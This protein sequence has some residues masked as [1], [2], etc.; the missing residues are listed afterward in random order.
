MVKR[1]LSF[2]LLTLALIGKVNAQYLSTVPPLAGGNGSGGVT[3][4]LSANASVIIDTIWCQFGGTGT[5]DIWYNTTAISG[6]PSISAPAWTNVVTGYA[7][8]SGFIGIPIPATANLMMSAGQT[9]GFYVGQGTSGTASVTYTTW[10]A[11]NVDTFFNNDITIRTGQQIGYGGPM[12]SPPNHPRQF[13]GAISYHLGIGTD[14]SASALVS[15]AA[16][17]T[18]GSTVAVSMELRCNASNPITTASVGYQLNNLPPVTGTWN[19]NIATGQTAVHTFPGN[20]TLPTSGTHILKV[21][22]TSPNGVNPDLNPMNDTLRTTIC[23]ALP[24]GTYTVGARTGTNFQTLQDA[25]NAIACG[26]IA[27]NV[28]FVLDTGTYTGSHV[29]NGPIAGTSQFN[30]TFVSANQNAASCRVENNGSGPV[31]RI[32]NV[33]NV[34]IRNISFQKQNTPTSNTEVPIHVKNGNMINILGCIAKG[35]STNN[36]NFNLSSIL[37]ENSSYVTIDSTTVGDSYYGIRF[38]GTA[39]PNRDMNNTVSH[40]NIVNA[41]YYGIYN[42]NQNTLV[43]DNNRITD[44]GLG[45]NNFAYGIYCSGDTST[46]ITNNFL[47]GIVPRYG[48]YLTNM[49]GESTNPNKVNNNVI[50]GVHYYVSGAPTGI[51]VSS[52]TTNGRDAIDIIHN[53][54]NI[55]TA[56]TSTSNNSGPGGLYITGT[57]YAALQIVNNTFNLKATQG[58]T[59]DPTVR[60]IVIASQAAVD[61]A[62]MNY[63][64]YF[65]GASNEVSRIAGT[66]YTTLA[67]H[68]AGT[69]RDANSLSL[70]PNYVSSSLPRP[71]SSAMDNMGTVTYVTADITG[72]TR[73]VLT[74]DIGAYEFTPSPVEAQMNSITGL[75]GGCGL[76]TDT[77][78][79][80]I[81]NLG[82]ATLTN[83]P[84]FYSVNGA[85]PVA[86]TVPGPVSAGQTAT[87]AF[88][89]LVNLAT[90]GTY[91]VSAWVKAVGDGNAVNDT[92]NFR[93]SSLRT[94][95]APDTQNFDGN[96]PVW[97]A[98]GT[99]SSWQ[100]GAP[101]GSVINTA[102]S[103]PN[104]WTT[105]LTSNYNASENSFVSSECYNFSAL[106]FPVVKF[107][108]NYKT[109]ATYDGSTFEY[110]TDGGA[111]WTRLGDTATGPNW[112][113]NYINRTYY[114]GPMWVGN[115]S[116]WL[117][118]EHSLGTITPRTSVMFRFH[119]YA[120]GSVQD[121]G[122][123]MD[124]F[125]I[126]DS[127]M[128]LNPIDLGVTAIIKPSSA[129]GLSTNDTVVVNVKNF[130]TNPQSNIPVSYTVNG[131]APVTATIPGPI[132][133][134]TSAVFTFPTTANL[135]TPNQFYTIK[136]YT[137]MQGDAMAYN[138]STSKIVFNNPV[139]SR[140]D[141]QL[142][143]ITNGGFSSGGTNS[144]WA[145]GTPAN[146]FIANAY[147]PANAW[148]TNLTGNYNGSENSWL[149]SNCYDL[150]Q[151]TKP[152]IKFAITYKTEKTWDGTILEYTTDN[153][154]NW[155]ILGDTATGTKWYNNYIT[156]TYYTG[157][158]WSDTASWDIADH[159]L[160]SLKTFPKVR[161]RF[162]F[163][164]D[165]SVNYEG[166]AIDNFTVYDSV[167]KP[168]TKRSIGVEKFITP[169]ANSNSN[170][171]MVTVQVR[172]YGNVTVYA[173]FDITFTHNGS[174]IQTQT[175]VLSAPFNPGDSLLHTFTIPYAATTNGPQQLCSWTISSGLDTISTDD[176]SCIVVNSTVGTRN[177][178][179]S[180]FRIYPN[181]A[182][183]VV[184]FE[185]EGMKAGSLVEMYNLL[186]ARVVSRV[187]SNEEAGQ[188]R[189][190]IQLSELPAGTYFCQVLGN[191]ERISAKLVI[192]H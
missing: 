185:L 137:G 47:G 67:A 24:G 181:P 33:P 62:V 48:L 98:S 28:T 146:T 44:C 168:T 159:S 178:S 180:M 174:V 18:S 191:G 150:T 66:N 122:F 176:S 35:S 156:R 5:V 170:T 117:N 131:G 95:L 147:T 56:S 152:R 1:L 151:F 30:L 51:Y 69:S 133:P 3:F 114:N 154:A 88:S 139:Y 80:T 9:W 59:L 148:V 11:S 41:Y 119:F 14:V 106:A 21:W 162:H 42:T 163:Y 120:D 96:V 108:L 13:N 184:T 78:I 113:N 188:G 17:F 107:D 57:A 76:S 123:A 89:T 140:T 125:T 172:N 157:P 153:G 161:F 155:K 58:S 136:A 183:D 6:P 7:V 141:S 91:N 70:D 36:T 129:C 22:A 38:N 103:S 79:V 99:S 54:V 115:S 121:D 49:D 166:V 145:W 83:V 10:T 32:Q 186:G 81:Q 65:T 43:I 94:I 128:F 169:T 77:V 8:S 179:N 90:A 134:S 100:W 149:M 109:E 39:A 52:S 118:G 16:P 171:A 60:G 189:L 82:T 132:A 110:S 34:S 29:L 27:G 45:T 101:N 71:L 73:S 102:V 97:V 26:G 12:P 55:E 116:G 40:S 167:P 63:N 135:S 20:L 144:S 25:I 105:G 175:K 4:N 164:S 192:Q 23:F 138:D 2:M 142:F 86:G 19:G 190:Q 53:T 111:T 68:Q 160:D 64:N 126:Y 130:G 112:Y 92:A 177:L 15:P 124:N 85:T 104:V 187:I 87:Y 61:S 46:S 75:N 72:A 31:F 74:P 84:V 93:L 173:P 37:V 50:S 143:D 165:G 182:N 127:S 158:I